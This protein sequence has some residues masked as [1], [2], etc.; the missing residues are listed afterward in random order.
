MH[1]VR[2][3]HMEVESHFLS[4]DTDWVTRMSSFAVIESGKRSKGLSKRG[5]YNVGMLF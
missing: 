3:K 4:W 1:N 2:E 5:I